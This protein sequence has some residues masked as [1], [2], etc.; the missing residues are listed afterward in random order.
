MKQ[1]IE[2]RNSKEALS[3]VKKNGTEVQYFLYPEFEVHTN[4]I[5][6]GGIQ[7]WHRH[8]QVEEVIV[9]TSGK[10]SIETIENATLERAEVKQG[11]V[12]RVKNSIHRLL[13][14]N[15][16]SAS[17]IVFRFVPQGVSQ[18]D[19]IK[20]DKCDCEEFVKKIMVD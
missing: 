14:R 20:N 3:R 9:V 8:Q 4:K 6:S 15:R 2:I 5:P 17:F 7:D 12:L 11:D 13:N 10:I 1:E 19:I 16:T 18:A